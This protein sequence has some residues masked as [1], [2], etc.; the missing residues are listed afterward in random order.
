MFKLGISQNYRLKDSLVKI[1]IEKT[2]TLKIK[3]FNS[4]G[5]FYINIDPD[6]SI[7]YSN[8]AL[9]VSQTID[10]KRGIAHA[11]S[12][13]G[14]AL[15]KKGD[16]T[17]ALKYYFLCIK[18]REELN[19]KRGLGI[20]YSRIGDVFLKSK[21]PEMALGYEVRSLKL[22][23]ETNNLPAISYSYNNLGSIYRSLMK[24]D[25]SLIYFKKSLEIKKQLNDIGPMATSLGNI[26]SVYFLQKKYDEALVDGLHAI[27]LM[28]ENGI[29]NNLPGNYHNLGGIY[30]ELN[31][32]KHA[33]Y[34]LYKSMALNKSLGA[35]AN[36]AEDYFQLSIIFERSNDFKTA[37]EYQRMFTDLR[38]SIINEDSNSQLAEMETKYQTDKKEKENLLLQAK[39][40]LS[41]ETIKKQ[42][43]ISYFIIACLILA[44]LFGFFIFRGYRQKQKANII[45]TQQKEDVEAQK[46]VVESQKHLIELHQQETIDSI[47]Y[48]KR[49]QFALLANDALLENSFDQ[50]FV[51]FKPKDI[52]SGDFYWAA[53]KEDNFYLAVCDSTGHGVPGAFMS[54]LNISFLN[55]AINEKNITEPHEILNHVRNKLI[56]HMEDGRD[57]MDAIL[58]CFNRHT[59]K[60]TYAAANNAIIHIRKS[61]IIELPYDKMPVGKGENNNSFKLFHLEQQ[62]GDLLYLYTDGFADQFGGPNG[63]KFKYKNLNELVLSASNES[64]NKQ[65]GL[66]EKSFIDWKGNLEQVDDICIIGIRF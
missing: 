26:S 30:T 24:M 34:Y 48:A 8:L 42:R 4:L 22:A 20:A 13:I 51:L 21:K 65:H 12:N 39:D 36:L 15:G 50:H 29:I 54:L 41:T 55:E 19:D 45:I 1:S 40:Q 57:G 25:S 62:T 38:D 17:D 10:F 46:K 33:K 11:Y 66:L 3:A 43:T 23:K 44:V 53:E 5:T 35:K 27:K 37:L 59:N 18:V 31:D 60:I 7:L 9:K 16:Y 6:S 64:M 58:I 14:L 28:E 52:V 61:N 32:L 63:K 2:D 49:I 47:N 56:S